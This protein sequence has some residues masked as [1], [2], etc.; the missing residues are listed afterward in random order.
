MSR[1]IQITA[2]QQKI[3]RLQAQLDYLLKIEELEAKQNKQI[4]VKEDK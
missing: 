3:E 4:A 1:Q 2:L